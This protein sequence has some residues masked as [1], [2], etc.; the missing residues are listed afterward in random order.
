[1]FSR[2]V[3]DTR[4][5]IRWHVSFVMLGVMRT[6]FMLDTMLKF[7]KLGALFMYANIDMSN[8]Q[9]LYTLWHLP[10]QKFCFSVRTSS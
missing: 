2:L 4:C 6:I 7:V 5:L 8:Y 10:F 1:M 3:S 9:I